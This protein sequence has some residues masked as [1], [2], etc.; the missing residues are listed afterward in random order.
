MLPSIASNRLGTSG[1][2]LT[3]QVRLY[4]SKKQCARAEL[5]QRMV[6][7]QRGTVR[8]SFHALAQKKGKVPTEIRWLPG[9]GQR[10]ECDPAVL[11]AVPLI[12][13]LH[14]GC[15]SRTAVQGSLCSW[16]RRL[17]DVQCDLSR[18]AKRP[19]LVRLSLPIE[20]GGFPCGVWRT[21]PY[22]K[23]HRSGS[24]AL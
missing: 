9:R 6:P 16:L 19:C 2:A 7:L 14:V 1:P 8:L 12:L 24:L 18:P 17:M 15:S 23:K 4:I 13:H 10:S 5:T 20:Q 11:L 22:Y 3:S 21:R